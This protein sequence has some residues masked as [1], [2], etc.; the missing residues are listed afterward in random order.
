MIFFFCNA[1]ETKNMI[2]L[3]LS[4]KVNNSIE[5]FIEKSIDSILPMFS[6]ILPIKRLYDKFNDCNP[7]KFVTSSRIA[8]DKL[9]WEKST[10]FTNWRIVLYSRILP[11][12]QAMHFQGRVMH[13][14]NILRAQLSCG[15]VNY[16]LWT[17]HWNS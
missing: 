17:W 16:Y 11:L 4:Y 15:G 14:K 9:L 7:Q 1:E 3:I 12:S 2:E 6:R 13:H 8:L 10:L 5:L